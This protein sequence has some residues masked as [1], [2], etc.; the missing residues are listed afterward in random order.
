MWIVR[1]ALARPYTIIVMTLLMLIGGGAS[2]RLMSTD[3]FPTINIPVVSVIWTYNGLAADEFEKRITIYSEYALSSNVNDVKS[4]ESQTIDGVGVIRLYFHPGVKSE[5]AIAQAT[6]VSQAILRRMPAGVQPPILLRYMADSVPLIQLSLSSDSL[7]ESQLY[8]YGIFRVRQ[9]LAAVPGSTLPAPYGGKIRQLRVEL[10]NQ[11]LQGLSLS[12]RDVNNAINAQN[13]M[14]PSGTARIGGTEYRV[15]LNNSPIVGQEIANIPIREVNGKLIYIR[16]V[17]GVHDGAAVQNNVVNSDGTRSVLLTVLKNGSASTLD[18]VNQVKNLLPT[19]RASAPKGMNIQP[20]FDQSFFVQA[21]VDNVIHEGL[22]AAFLTGSLILLFLGSW[23]ST[24]I[25]LISI[26]ISILVSLT[27]LY[28]LGHTLNIMTLGGLSL[29]IGILVDDATV[30]IENVHR[31]LGQGKSLLQ[32]ILDGAEQIATPALVATACICIIFLPVALL[33]GPARYLFIPFAQAVVFAVAT[34]YWLS[35]TLVP[36]L[37]KTLEKPHQE[38]NWNR[39]FLSA[40]E[41]FRTRYSALLLWGLQHPRR[42]LIPALVTL[43]SA[44]FLA[45]LVGRDFFPS[46]DAGQIRMHVKD[47]PGQRIEDTERTFAHVEDEIRRVIP[48][49]EIE[50]I[51]NN[52]GVPAEAYNL[53]F[54]DSATLGPSDGELLISLKSRKTAEHTRQLR[55]VLQDKF[56]DL[57]FYFQPAD[58]VSQILSFGLPAPINVRVAGYNKAENLAIARGLMEDLKKIPGAVDVHMHQDTDAP[59]LKVEVDR[60]LL[61]RQNVT[62]ANLAD[63]LLVSLSSNTQVTPNYWVDPNTG[64]PYFVAVQTPTQAISNFQELL[65][66]PVT[67]KQLLRNVAVLKRGQANTVVNHYNIQPVYDLFVN[68]QSRDLGGVSTDVK[69]VI[70]KWQKKM[71]PGN[72]ILLRGLVDSMDSS[73]YRL[74]WGFAAA[75]MLVFL[76]LVVNFQSFTDA[77]IIIAALP[78]AMAGIVWGLFLTHT[79]FNVPSLM[80]AIMTLGVATANSVLIVS[81]AKERMEEGDD[82]FT[83]AFQAGRTRLRPVMMTALAMIIGMI[84]MSLALGQGAEQNAPLGRAVI[85]GLSMATLFTLFFVPAVFALV[86]R[87]KS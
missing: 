57:T 68:T 28:A 26:P 49:Q 13:L 39:G 2:L 18:V 51:T 38:H 37:V 73:F 29:A 71:A 55:A 34:S 69:A 11:K 53:A 82:A 41:R 60:T 22:I 19:L 74:A 30:E 31:N 84:P 40:F 79:T 25:V 86:R 66:L 58:I 33:D 47:R 15:A 36:L 42:I 20:L 48:S 81:F 59:Q 46:V 70:E 44:G 7:S 65:N 50:L 35:R 9:A 1:L 85:G 83:A 14:L 45:P 17:A 12:P 80:G 32:A 64:I 75:L 61:A 24:L 78:G 8:D 3:I 67:G 62:Q 6:A 72:Q 77:A 23:R 27:M 87:R 63:D 76:L 52:I 10:D 16:D 5:T 21:A 4:M 56:P 54:G 43:M